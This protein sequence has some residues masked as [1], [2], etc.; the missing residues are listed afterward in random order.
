M[1]LGFVENVFVY[2][3]CAISFS[4]Y[5]VWMTPCSI[6]L[7]MIPFIAIFLLLKAS[8]FRWHIYDNPN[9]AKVKSCRLINMKAKILYRCREKKNCLM[10]MILNLTQEAV[11][12]MY[13]MAQYKS[14]PAYPKAPQSACFTD[15][16]V[17]KVIII[18][19]ESI[20]L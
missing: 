8:G 16:R 19:Q 20:V 12:Q 6:L 13:A 10:P 4:N 11:I 2:I 7:Q 3:T 17:S 18:Y 14:S 1:G 15:A 5:W 9:A